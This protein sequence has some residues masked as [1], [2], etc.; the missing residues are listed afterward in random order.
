MARTPLTV[1]R[2]I[3]KEAPRKMMKTADLLPIPNH[4]MVI[5]IQAKGGMGLI[6]SMSGSIKSHTCEDHPI[7]SPKGTPIST[8]MA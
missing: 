7:T 8:A 2:R 4:R 5:G 1:F 3:G 6:I